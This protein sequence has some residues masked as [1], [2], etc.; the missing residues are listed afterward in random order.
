MCIVAGSGAHPATIAATMTKDARHPKRWRRKSRTLPALCVSARECPERSPVTKTEVRAIAQQT[1]LITSR[2]AQLAAQGPGAQLAWRKSR[3]AT[4][5][6]RRRTSCTP[7]DQVYQDRPRAARHQGRDEELTG[8]EASGLPN[9][10]APPPS[11]KLQFAAPLEPTHAASHPRKHATSRGMIP[12]RG[13]VRGIALCG[14]G[15]DRGRE[16]ASQT[17]HQTHSTTSPPI[18]T[19]SPCINPPAAQPPP[20]PS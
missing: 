15:V 18:A 6:P 8:V 1:Q 7:L 17:L 13:R 11:G 3:P 14:R 20:S 12:R 2:A 19:I 9:S 4:H 5:V 10:A 16:H